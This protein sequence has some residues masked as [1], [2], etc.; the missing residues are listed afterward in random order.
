M[1]VEFVQSVSKV[2]ALLWQ[3]VLI[4]VILNMVMGK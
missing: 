1:G 3:T 2:L 4:T